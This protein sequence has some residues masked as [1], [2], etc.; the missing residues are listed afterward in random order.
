MNVANK[1][2]GK[3]AEDKVSNMRE[4]VR[5]EMCLRKKP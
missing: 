2:I 5:E 4:V 1:L 3:N